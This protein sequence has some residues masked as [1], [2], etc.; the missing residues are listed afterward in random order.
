LLKN[1]S[2][3]Y[4]LFITLVSL[5][6]FTIYEHTLAHSSMGN[7]AGFIVLFGIIIYASLSV[8]HHAEVLAEK[9]GFHPAIGAYFGGLFLKGEYFNVTVD[10]NI[11]S[12]QGQWQCHADLQALWPCP[13]SMVLLV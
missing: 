6:I 8:A 1:I 2:K 11:L 9:F 10:Q 3:E 12:H 7:I 4:A 13:F 5:V